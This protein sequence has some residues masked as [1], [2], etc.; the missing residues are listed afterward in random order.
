MNTLEQAEEHAFDHAC[1]F[2]LVI[3]IVLYGHATL[4]GETAVK[5]DTRHY[6]SE[7]NK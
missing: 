3:G 6:F 1:I 7:P 2:K 5:R 4:N